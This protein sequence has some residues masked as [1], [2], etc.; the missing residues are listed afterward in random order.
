MT[1]V[2]NYVKTYRQNVSKYMESV[3]KRALEDSIDSVIE[4]AHHIEH[5]RAERIDFHDTTRVFGPESYKYDVFDEAHNALCLE[6]WNASSIGSGI[7]C[8]CVSDAISHADN[9]V[10]RRYI[11]PEILKMLS[12]TEK[13]KRERYERALYE[14]YLGDDEE[15]AFRDASDNDCFRGRY[16]LLAFLFFI[17]DR[18]RFLPTSPDTFDSIF[19]AMGLSFKMSK[20]CSWD[21]Y[22][23]FIAIISCVRDYLSRSGVCEHEVSLLD[24]HSA[25]WIMNYP[26]YMTWRSETK[27]INT[28]MKPKKKIR[29]ADG[30]NS[31]QCGRCEHFFR[32]SSR[33]PECG[34]LVKE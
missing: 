32:Q 14:I 10:N 9:L 19:D 4:F 18:D 6:K 21:N 3:N 13:Q 26:K 15:K 22:C 1:L 29:K 12:T 33:C 34:Q 24:A 5:N 20:R 17:K 2:N 27:D 23:E 16:A 31:Y 7:I 11:V 28:P 30:T 8:E 25:V